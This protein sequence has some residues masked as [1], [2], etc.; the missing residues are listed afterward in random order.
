[1]K[2]AIALRM[3]MT[4]NDT[5]ISFSLARITPP[6][7]AIAEPPQMAVPDEMRYDALASILRYLPNRMPKNITNTT[8]A[9][10]KSIP[11]AP[12]LSDSERFMPK[13]KPT[14]DA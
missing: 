4:P 7:A 8:E 14:T 2:R 11:S 5:A 13:P 12:D 3:K 6:T 9:M 1:M 10:V